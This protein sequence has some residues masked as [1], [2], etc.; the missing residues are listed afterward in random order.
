MISGI[1][2]FVNLSQVATYS[3]FGL[4]IWKDKDEGTEEKEEGEG[5]RGRR[6]RHYILSFHSFLPS[7]KQLLIMGNRL[8]SPTGIVG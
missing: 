6:K 8:T 1:S 5:R 3:H 2:P 7:S 4:E